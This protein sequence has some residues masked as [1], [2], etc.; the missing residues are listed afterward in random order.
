VGRI[1]VEEILKAGGIIKVYSGD[2]PDSP[3]EP[4]GKLLL[5]IGEETLEEINKEHNKEARKWLLDFVRGEVFP[6]S[7][8]F[9][10]HPGMDDNQDKLHA[11]FKVF[12]SEGLVTRKLEEDGLC[13][14]MPTE[15]NQ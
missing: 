11:A 1:K 15:V 6:F 13:V 8:G 9:R 12:E 10:T 3:I 2:K 5:T 7:K 14:W 4:S